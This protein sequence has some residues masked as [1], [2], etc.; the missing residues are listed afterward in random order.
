MIHVDK[1]KKR[2]TI[3]VSIIVLSVKEVNS[4]EK[5]NEKGR[6]NMQRGRTA[7]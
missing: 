2:K 4:E 5:K 1:V 6:E 3:V 7:L